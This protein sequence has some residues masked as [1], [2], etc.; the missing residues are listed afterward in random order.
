MPVRGRLRNIEFPPIADI[1]NFQ[2]V[3]SER[4]ASPLNDNPSRTPFGVL[5]CFVLFQIAVGAGDLIGP[6]RELAG[7]STSAKLSW[8]VGWISSWGAYINPFGLFFIYLATIKWLLIDRHVKVGWAGSA[9]YY[10]IF[11]LYYGALFMNNLNG[12]LHGEFDRAL[13]ISP[14][15]LLSAALPLSLAFLLPLVATFLLN[16]AYRRHRPVRKSEV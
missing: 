16:T 8:F 14:R 6:A 15:P 9:A 7:L 5:G 4:Q 2:R 13:G 3:N 10:V 1:D 12:E 11:G